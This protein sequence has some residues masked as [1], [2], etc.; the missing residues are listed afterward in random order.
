MQLLKEQ[1][2]YTQVEI[3][4]MMSQLGVKIAESTFSGLLS[5][6]QAGE[7]T[8]MKVAKVL[9]ELVWNECGMEWFD[10]KFIRTAG[11]DFIPVETPTSNIGT[12]KKGYVMFDD[13]RLEVEKKVAFFMDAQEEVIEFG[14]T[15]SKFSNNLYSS[16]KGEFKIHVENLLSRNVKFKCFLLDPKTVGLFNYFSDRADI[17]PIENEFASKINLSIASLNSIQ[18][19]LAM[20]GFANSLEVFSY[21]HFPYN[22]F[23]A[24]DG[25]KKH[26]KMI[27]SHYLYGKTRADSP[28]LIIYKKE[29]PALFNTYW[30]SLNALMKNAKRIIPA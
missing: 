5:N 4:G 15:L 28:S 13:R 29:T 7:K 16:N 11:D 19:D 3:I 12:G 9:R 17:H 22:Y 30:D 26:G 25:A 1:Q 21:S 18:K 24:V 14:A 6:G 2:P 27:V 23:M 8:L 10:G 20:A